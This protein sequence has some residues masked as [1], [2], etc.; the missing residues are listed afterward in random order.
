[1]QWKSWKVMPDEIKTEV[2]EQLS[3]PDYVV[4]FLY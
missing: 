4:F 2:R 1:M 3:A